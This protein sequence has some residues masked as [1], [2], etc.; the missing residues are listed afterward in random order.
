MKYIRKSLEKKEKS[1]MPVTN[2]KMDKDNEAKS[3]LVAKIE[4]I[5]DDKIKL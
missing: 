2:F 5:K 1:E 3:T 4:T